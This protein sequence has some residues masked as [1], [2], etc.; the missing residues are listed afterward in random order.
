M[1]KYNEESKA[2][3]YNIIKDTD[4]KEK[5]RQ[6]RTTLRIVFLPFLSNKKIITQG[7]IYI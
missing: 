1:K 5:S 4:E 3:S 2:N 7:K 6:V